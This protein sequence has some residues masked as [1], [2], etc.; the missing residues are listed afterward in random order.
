MKEINFKYYDTALKAIELI[1]ESQTGVLIKD[2]AL[3]TNT[4]TKIVSNIIATLKRR[5]DICKI[6]REKIKSNLFLYQ[7]IEI[8][9]DL[10]KPILPT[11]S[12]YKRKNVL[13]KEEVFEYMQTLTRKTFAIKDIAEKFNIPE[14]SAKTFVCYAKEN[15]LIN[16]FKND[17]FLID[18]S[19][20]N[21]VVYLAN[22][23]LNNVIGLN[24]FSHA[25]YGFYYSADVNFNNVPYPFFDLE[26][27]K[28]IIKDTDLHNAYNHTIIR[29]YCMAKSTIKFYNETKAKLDEQYARKERQKRFL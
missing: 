29:N 6:E 21:K 2:I 5:K 15:E 9:T 19:I 26:Q 22:A 12:A 10:V 23:R 13:K 25:R 16:N 17:Y 7:K 4:S 18:E 20:K 28:N 1:N 8:D 27:A 14:K 11:Q 24:K 3:K